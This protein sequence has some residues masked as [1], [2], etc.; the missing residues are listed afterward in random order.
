M[1]AHVVATVVDSAAV[2]VAAE[3]H[4][5]LGG[6]AG[7]EA[8]ELDSGGLVMMIIPVKTG[9]SSGLC[10]MLDICNKLK[11]LWSDNLRH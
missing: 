3:V 2:S 10:P 5:A 11:I 7:A 9:I 8:V 4:G 1:V 6:A